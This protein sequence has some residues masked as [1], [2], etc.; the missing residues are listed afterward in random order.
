MRLK[1]IVIGSALWLL[2]TPFL[3]VGGQWIL[4]D[5]HWLRIFLLFAISFVLMSILI[6][7]A[8]K[9][10]RIPREQWLLAA[11]L[12]FLPTLLLDPFSSAFFPLVFPNMAPENAGIFGGWMLIC[13]AGGLVGAVFPLKAADP[14]H[15]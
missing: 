6:R 11:V 15:R 1:L 12:L 3:R 10:A 2:A 14:A 7:R 9:G 4:S 8:C 5:R 13:C